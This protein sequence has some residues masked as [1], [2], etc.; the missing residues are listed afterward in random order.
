[1]TDE[2]GPSLAGH[3][4]GHARGHVPGRS[5]VSMTLFILGSAVFYAGAMIAMKLWGQI[6]PALLLAVIIAFAGAGIWME[7][8]AL[9]VERLGMVYVLILGVECVLIAIASALWFGESF[10]PRE[11]IGGGLIVLGTAIAWT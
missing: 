6:S 4:P 7:I 3:A 11:I 9:Q 1:M 10:S 8:G 5:A 2:N